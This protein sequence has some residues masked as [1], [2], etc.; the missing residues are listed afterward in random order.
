LE[1]A[2]K[3]GS[4]LIFWTDALVNDDIPEL[5]TVSRIA[6]ILRASAWIARSAAKSFAGDATQVAV[7]KRTPMAHA[8]VGRIQTVAAVVPGSGFDTSARIARSS[9]QM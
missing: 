1:S 2:D 7:Q 8:Q 3:R 5:R 9:P 4:R 6:P